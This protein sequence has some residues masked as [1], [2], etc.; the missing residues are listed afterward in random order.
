[1][2]T[3]LGKAYIQIV[4]SAKGITASI[5]DVI[6]KPMSENGAH[7]GSILGSG[8]V[9]SL[10]KVLTT[11]ALG[12]VVGDSL[13]EGGKLQQSIGGVETL[14]GSSAD[15]LK[16]YAMNAFK[17][18]GVSANEYMEQATSFASALIQS[19]G[20]NTKQAVEIA[21]TALKDMSD[22]SNKFGTSIED[23]QRAY[24]GFGRNNYTMLDNLKLGLEF[25]VAEYKLGY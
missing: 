5:K 21:N 2:A 22:N 19:C 7:G 9:K 3:D 4:P 23:I 17:T 14:F 1:M 25:S 12:K 10:T 18:S 20:G 11:G 6:E 8:V 15:R 13:T 16:K 24:Q